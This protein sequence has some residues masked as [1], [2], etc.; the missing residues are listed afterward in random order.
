M[1]TITLTDEQERK[2]DRLLAEG[3]YE[4]VEA[5]I[6][7]ALDQLDTEPLT[8]A[9]I[10]AAERRID[11]YFEEADRAIATGDFVPFTDT[12]LD[13]LDA[14]EQEEHEKQRRR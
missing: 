10:A 9:E 12:L 11:A 4:S 1:K 5:V 13:E 7:E 6:D 14:A 3:G 2:L 8:E